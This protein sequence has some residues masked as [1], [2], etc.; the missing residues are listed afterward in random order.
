MGME[1]IRSLFDSGME[2]HLEKVAD[3]IQEWRGI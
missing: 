3:L 1:P 2:G